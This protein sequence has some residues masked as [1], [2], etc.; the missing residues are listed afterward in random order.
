MDKISTDRLIFLMK[1]RKLCGPKQSC[2]VSRFCD[3]TVFGETDL[4]HES[5]QS[6]YSAI[7]PGF[8]RET[9]AFL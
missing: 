4:N 6:G 3:C 1:D 5:I 8:Q 2:P 7:K 9:G